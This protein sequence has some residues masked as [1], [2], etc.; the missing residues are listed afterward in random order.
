MNYTKGPWMVGKTNCVISENDNGLELNGAKGQEAIEYYGGNLICESVS[1]ANAKLI[2]AAPE[3]LEALKSIS[4]LIMESEGVTSFHVGGD[5][6][7]WGEFEL[8]KKIEQAIK[9]ATE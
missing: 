7:L 3:M 6:V 2:A 1:E 5:I 4:D 9:K 8:V